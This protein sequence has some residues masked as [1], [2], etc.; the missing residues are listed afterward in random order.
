MK[1]LAILQTDCP[2]CHLMV[3][4]LN[5][6]ASAGAN[7]SGLSQDPAALTDAFIRQM[8]I[9]FPIDL[10]T[11]YKRSVEL[12]IDTVPTLVLLDDQ[13]GIVRRGLARIRNFEM[14]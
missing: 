9:A 6:L 3:P 2:T 11:G 7:V 13:S 10:D 5:R 8:Q 4:Y 1:L 12:G 14:A